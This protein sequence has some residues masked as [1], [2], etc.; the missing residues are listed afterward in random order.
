[1]ALLQF[2]ILISLT[3][4]FNVCCGLSSSPLKD[5]SAAVILPGY[6]TGDRDFR[7]LAKTLTE[8]GIPTVVVPLPVWAWYPCAGGRSVRPILEKL[9][10]TVK[11]VSACLT[12][13]KDIVVPPYQYSWKDCWDDFWDNPGGVYKVGGTDKVDEFPTDVEPR[14]TYPPPAIEPKRKIIIIGHSAGGFISRVYLSKRP[15][16]GKVYNG[17]ELVHSLVTLGT[18]HMEA[19]GAAFENVKW[20]NR[21]PLPIRGLAVGGIGFPGNSSGWF[22]KG[23]YDFCGSQSDGSDCDG[24]GV[25][26][27]ESA[28]AM[29]GDNV[30][31]L[32]LDRVMHYPWRDAGI[33]GHLIAPDLVRQSKDGTPW[34]GD[35]EIV[36]KW[37]G[38]LK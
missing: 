28:M 23:S 5:A 11:H 17:Q 7:P 14:G 26:T 21:E 22:T 1:M 12:E 33:I 4:P 10:F 31:K 32:V 24:D 35:D 36:D 18:P 34:Y 8:R 6:L 20:I 13:G 19:A 9:E 3:I 25:T 37:I 38:F 29:N 16:G 27:I 15:Y 30:E 2:L